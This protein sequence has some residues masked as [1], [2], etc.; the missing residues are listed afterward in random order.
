MVVSANSASAAHLTTSQEMR[1]NS[2]LRSGLYMYCLP[3]LVGTYRYTKETDANSAC[4]Q[5]AVNEE[6]TGRGCLW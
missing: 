1:T 5:R 3:A 6:C 4:S 2:K